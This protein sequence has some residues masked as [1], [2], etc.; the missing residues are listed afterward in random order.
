M[1]NKWIKFENVSNKTKNGDLIDPT[2]IYLVRYHDIYI[3][4]ISTVHTTMMTGEQFQKFCENEVTN[5]NIIA[6]KAAI[7]EFGKETDNFYTYACAT[8]DG[9]IK[10]SYQYYIRLAKG[11]IKEEDCQ[12]R[13]AKKYYAVDNFFHADQIGEYCRTRGDRQNFINQI[14]KNL[15]V[16]PKHMQEDLVDWLKY[17]YSYYVGQVA[18]YSDDPASWDVEGVEEFD[19]YLNLLGIKH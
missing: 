11:E 17:R 7:M 2:A 8:K 3:R 9:T 4:T 6:V 18:K 10:D 15:D 12:W 14:F 16:F 19:G 5:N 1:A 13:A